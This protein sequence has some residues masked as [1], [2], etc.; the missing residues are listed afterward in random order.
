ME[1]ETRPVAAEPLT[2][3]RAEYEA[4]P[5]AEVTCVLCRQRVVHEFFRCNGQPLCGE[6]AR[7]LDARGL[8][9]VRGAFARALGLG[10]LAAI[11]G[12]AVWYGI[13]AVTGFE[14]GLIGVAVGWFVGAAVR[15]GS[16]ARG[17]WLYQALAIVLVYVAIASTY[18]PYV[19]EGVRQGE[20]PETA[21][22]IKNVLLF[23]FACF[24]ALAAP[25]LIAFADVTSGLIGFV[26]LGIALFEA[27]KL[28]KRP[29]LIVEGPFP[30][31]TPVAAAP[32]LTAAASVAP[33]EL[34]SA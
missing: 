22:A 18:V 34:P 4:P 31:A 13:R 11:A 21:D 16:G 19:L 15:R 24:I 28:N 3:D 30:L 14:L 33:T 27:W 29:E 26:I 7:Q 23:V 5:P 17:G 10:V 8:P 12:A 20:T 1:S 9:P 2:F 6:C 25:F 32:A